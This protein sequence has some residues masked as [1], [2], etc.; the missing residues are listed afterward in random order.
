MKK[1]SLF[2]IA[3]IC[4]VITVAVLANAKA[5][6]FANA[7]D[8]HDANCVWHH[9]EET[10]ATYNNNGV[11]EYWICC[12]H[13]GLGPVFSEPSSGSK[14]DVPHTSGFSS[15]IT[16]EDPRYI[17]PYKDV[18]TFED[19]VV[20]SF[21]S[22]KQ[23]IKSISVA[24]GGSESDKSLHVVI[25][26]S[27]FG[28]Y[29]SKY[30][31]DQV[32]SDPEVVA[33]N[34]EAK[35]SAITSNFRH[36]TNGANVCYEINNTGYGLTT[37]WKTFTFTRAFYNSYIEGDAV[38]FGGALAGDNY[39]DI[40]NIRP[41]KKNLDS[42]GFENGRL[43]ASLVSTAYYKYGPTTEERLFAQTSNSGIVTSVSFDYN[44]KSEGL[45]S[46]KISKVDGYAAFFLNSAIYNSLGDNDVV[47]L[48]IYSTCDAIGTDQ[49]YFIDGLNGKT[50]GNKEANKWE[51]FSFGKKQM[52][53]DG[54]FLILQGPTAGD[55]MFDNIQ[56]STLEAVSE[57]T[58]DLGEKTIA[59]VSAST[60]IA[61]SESIDSVFSVS[62]DG[63]VI[64]NKITGF[65]SGA[66]TIPN[67]YLTEGDHVILARYIHQG[68]IYT[69]RI[70]V[71]ITVV[72]PSPVENL[73]LAY[74]SDSYYTLSGIN[75]I[76]RITCDDKEVP[77]EENGT[78]SV[79]I[80][81]AALIELCGNASKDIDLKVYTIGATYLKTLSIT[82]TG[83]T[84]PKSIPSYTGKGIWTHAYSSTNSLATGSNYT[85]YYNE[86]KVS[87]FADTGLDV[88]YEQAGA[89]GYSDTSLPA[90]YRYLLDN[91]AKFNKKVMFVDQALGA[92]SRLTTSLIGIDITFANGTTVRFNT[93]AELDN[94]VEA[95][96]AIL[97]DEPNC[98]G[99]S[100]GDEQTYAMLCGGFG[101]VLQSIHRVLNK[102]NRNDFFVNCNMNPM[103]ARF[104]DLAGPDNVGSPEKDWTTY[105]Y[106]YLEVSGNN[107]IQYDAYPLVD[108][109]KTIGGALY[110]D[111]VL[112]KEGYGIS[113]FGMRNI[114]LAAKI[115]AD[116]NVDLHVVTQALTNDNDRICNNSDVYFLNNTLM[117]F[118][119]KHISYFVYCCRAYTGT[120]TWNEEGSMLRVDGS[121]TK[122]YY[123]I[124]AMAHQIK[125]F[126]PMLSAFDYKWCHL[127]KGSNAADAWFYNGACDNSTFAD[128]YPSSST[129]GNVSKY[130]VDKSWGLITGL[131]ESNGAKMYMIQNL[132][133]EFGASIIQ[134]HTITFDSNSYSYA[135]IFEAGLP[136]VVNLKSNDAT[137]SW[138]KRKILSLTLSSGH[139][140]FVMIF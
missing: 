46:L 9:Y 111:G 5:E 100:V 123:Y 110:T 137:F 140:A 44:K 28:V 109:T 20:P 47:T 104:E 13:S 51:T 125:A 136:R 134:N 31:L 77:F 98:F 122:L 6:S 82:V 93:T 119:V 48:D 86:E 85:Q 72:T 21:I 59:D 130:T 101:D 112:T 79:L 23:N 87:E 60:S 64:T 118:G 38:I 120:E 69:E 61:M 41:V 126:A 54:R 35:G 99:I 116:K 42:Y 103:N 107:Y 80:P 57:K 50:L 18:I 4:G 8:K 106:K 67:S 40:D 96:L 92:L 124:G 94:Y 19:G 30:Y 49:L 34:F 55:W 43:N 75:G 90:K 17:A 16:Q 7:A 128:I 63:T 117:G 37:E 102:L 115:A 24:D 26:G 52:S 133:N 74:L 65:T 91:A 68:R 83:A 12:T 1:I 25:K 66:I 84:S 97:L 62:V 132:H 11:K 32:F 105:M 73:T 36:K 138:N 39:I 129:Y 53:S 27:D 81:E 3:S 45:R 131:A 2:A 78:S 22:P 89:I 113:N 76:Y 70:K 127:Y 114:I 139:A 15:T 121:R 88:M 95:R 58:V 56:F 29:F 14:V 33:L 10:K 71:K 108:K 135:V